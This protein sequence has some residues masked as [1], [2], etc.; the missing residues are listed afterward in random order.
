ME[1]ETYQ[2]LMLPQN[3]KGWNK[4]E[5][6]TISTTEIDI[7]KANSNSGLYN[8]VAPN[9]FIYQSQHLYFTSNEEIKEGD[10]YIDDAS[11]VR[12]PITSDLTYWSVRK[13]YKKIVAST[14][15]S[16]RL[17]CIEDSFIKEY[18]KNNGSIKEV[19]QH[20]MDI[21]G[22]AIFDLLKPANEEFSKPSAPPLTPAS[23]EGYTHREM[24]TA[25]NIEGAS[26][27][28]YYVFNVTGGFARTRFEI[29]TNEIVLI[30]KRY[31]IESAIAVYNLI[32]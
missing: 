16:L 31:D 20:N 7:A 26:K 3:K 13:E 5:I 17:P 27:K 19:S 28:L 11:F 9:N 23:F 21:A 18:V 22:R 14:D 24:L 10:W 25:D 2:V 30:T 15:S 1:H 12:R 4:G 29:E 6:I 8:A 32:K